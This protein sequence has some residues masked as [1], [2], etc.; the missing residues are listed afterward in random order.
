MSFTLL[1]PGPWETQ[2][3][4]NALLPFSLAFTQEAGCALTSS[5][6][7][8]R[9][10]SRGEIV[11]PR[12][13]ISGAIKYSKIPKSPSSH[14]CETLTFSFPRAA[15]FH[16][17][18]SYKSPHPQ[19]SSLCSQEQVHGWI[20]VFSLFHGPL[21]CLISHGLNATAVSLL[22]VVQTFFYN[23]SNT[24]SVVHGKDRMDQVH[25]FAGSPLCSVKIFFPS[26]FIS[27]L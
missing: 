26:P 5:F 23:Y 22:N 16:S 9:S 18:K 6:W 7:A 4:E 8:W 25:A 1:V 27:V 17:E 21:G 20:I 15:S 2:A 3:G 19:T 12:N 10:S 24:V 13:S 11:F 14:L